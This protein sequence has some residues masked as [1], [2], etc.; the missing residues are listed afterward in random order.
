MVPGADIH[1]KTIGVIGEENKYPSSIHHYNDELQSDLDSTPSKSQQHFQYSM[2]GHLSSSNS[3]LSQLNER[4]PDA[5]NSSLAYVPSN[6]ND[7]NTNNP[8][9]LI[10]YELFP[11]PCQKELVMTLLENEMDEELLRMSNLEEVEQYLL[12]HCECSPLESRLVSKALKRRF[13]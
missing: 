6:S 10:L 4:H 7:A 9:A 1:C 12:R 2:S 3:L 5:D 11:K 8:F 13:P